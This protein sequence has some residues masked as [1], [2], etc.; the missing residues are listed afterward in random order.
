MITAKEAA[1]LSQYALELA[2]IRPE[3][4]LKRLFKALNRASEPKRD[5]DD[6]GVSYDSNS[7]SSDAS[8]SDGGDDAFG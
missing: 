8:D 2:A 6:D 5:D 7:F 3:Q 4:I 1:W